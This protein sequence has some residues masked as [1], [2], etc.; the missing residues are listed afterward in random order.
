MV[1]ENVRG[2]LI[3]LPVSLAE[4]TKALYGFITKTIMGCVHGNAIFK[5]SHL[6]E[7]N[8]FRSVGVTKAIPVSVYEK[9]IKA[10]ITG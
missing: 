3:G 5:G 9:T 2:M 1:H 8:I 10:V 7:I 4:E 6:V